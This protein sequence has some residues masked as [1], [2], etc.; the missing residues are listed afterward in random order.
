MCKSTFVSK[1]KG[2]LLSVR[3]RG[4]EMLAF[5]NILRTYLMDAPLMSY[6]RRTKKTKKTEPQKRNNTKKSK[7]D[8]ISL[9]LTLLQN[10]TSTR[11]L[12]K[13]EERL[14]FQQYD[15]I[16]RLS[17]TSLQKPVEKLIYIVFG[18]SVITMSQAAITYSKL[19]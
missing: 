19:M 6:F 2:S 1:N 12:R 17:V 3:I 10:N 18:W 14:G 4:L 5:R 9:N 8:T 16:R 13:V 15:K 11:K 7:L